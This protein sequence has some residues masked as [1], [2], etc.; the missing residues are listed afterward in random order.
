[1]SAYL[2]ACLSRDEDGKAKL[3]GL[4]IFSEE[5]PTIMGPR[6]TALILKWPGENYDEAR[7]SLIAHLEAT[8][9]WLLP[10]RN[11]GRE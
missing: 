1:M 8:A 11:G 7:K 2:V 6:R 5:G 3:L 4:E 10:E 9:P